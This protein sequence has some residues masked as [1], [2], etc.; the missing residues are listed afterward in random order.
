MLRYNYVPAPWSIHPGIRKLEPGQYLR[1][2]AGRREPSVEAY[3][4]LPDVAQAGQRDP[5]AGSEASLDEL[6]GVL[7]AAVD[8]QMV[9]DVPLGAFVSGGIDS[10]TVTALMQAQSMQPVKTFTI[11]FH[12]AGYNE[13]EH[14]KAV[15]RHLGTDHTELYV[16][17]AQARDVIPS[18]PMMYDEPFA[19]SS[20]IPTFLV[21]Q[22]ARQHVTV[23]LSGDGG[24]ELFHGY[25]RH[26]LAPKLWRV[27]SRLPGPLRQCLHAT[28]TR[29][30]VSAWNVVL[31][32][33]DPL[34]PAS[35]RGTITGG[36]IHRVAR[37]LRCHDPAELYQTLVSLWPEPEAV[38]LGSNPPITV[39]RDPA[40]WGCAESFN[41]RMMLT[42]ALTY[43]PDDI[44]VKVDRAAMAV[45]LETRVPLLDHHVVEAAWRTPLDMKYRN[46][47]SKWAL[48]Q[49][50][51]KY[52]PRELIERPKMGFGLPIDTWLRGPLRDWAETLLDESRLR[53]EGYLD[54]A[55]IR[56]KWHEHLSGRNDWQ[57]HLWGVLM[58]QAW[59]EQ[60]PN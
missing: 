29:I 42:D 24:D 4:S 19:D 10:S 2:A 3:W 6:E 40:I 37:L 54:P 14:A 46:G 13:A 18:L 38:V 21:A 16:T 51:Y 43:L 34:L 49:I 58:F 8:R 30:P 27:F 12:E 22:L 15:A 11:G 48:R 53:Q 41:E 5:A 28:L 33:L 23:S 35:K 55:P 56:Q 57:H 32:G 7:K 17:S 60:N 39:A 47:Q 59:L 9:A 31:S 45:S 52:V 50:L 1:L 25:N 36:R 26:M 44:L 20:Q